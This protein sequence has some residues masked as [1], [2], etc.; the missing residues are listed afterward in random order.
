MSVSEEV[1]KTWKFFANGLI[2]SA[3]NTL[4]QQH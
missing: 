4:A 3:V 1:L 2:S